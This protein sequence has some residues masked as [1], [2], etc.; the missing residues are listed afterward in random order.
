MDVED[1]GE[2]LSFSWGDHSLSDGS[3]DVLEGGRKITGLLNGP[4]FHLDGSFPANGD[5]A[6]HAEAQ[7]RDV[8][9]FCELNGF[10][11]DLFGLTFQYLL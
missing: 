5:A 3:H 2:G 4:E 1:V 10:P 9:V 11:G 8:S 6:V 7:R